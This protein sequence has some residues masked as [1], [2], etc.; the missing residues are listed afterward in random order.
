MATT[1]SV[2]AAPAAA[3]GWAAM[4]LSRRVLLLRVALIAAI[5]LI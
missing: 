2:T 4:P 5:V 1:G 3:F